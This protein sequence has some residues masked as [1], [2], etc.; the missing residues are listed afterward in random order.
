MQCA[1]LTI[2][3]RMKHTY[4]ASGSFGDCLTGSNSD[5]FLLVLLNSYFPLITL[6]RSPV[7][8][9]CSCVGMRLSAV[10]LRGKRIYRDKLE[11]LRKRVWDSH[12]SVLKVDKLRVPE[13]LLTDPNC[14]LQDAEDMFASTRYDDALAEEIEIGVPPEVALKLE[15]ARKQR[16]QPWSPTAF[17]PRY[18]PNSPSLI[19][20]NERRFSKGLDQASL[21]TNTLI[22]PGTPPCMTDL[23]TRV[24]R[25]ICSTSTDSPPSD[26]NW[27]SHLRNS[28]ERAILHAH[29]WH[30][31]ETKLPRRFRPELPIWKHKAEF[32]IHPQQATRF[33]FQN[34]FRILDQQTDSIASAIDAPLKMS[35]TE[36]PPW[37]LTRD[38]FLE[39]HYFWGN[40]ARR[41]AFAE[42]HDVVVSGRNP[43]PCFVPDS[44]GIRELCVSHSLPVR[45][46]GPM[47]PLVD[48]KAT[49]YYRDD[50]T[51]GWLRSDRPYP[52]PHLITINF[53]L[54]N[55]WSDF[56]EPEADP[57]RPEQRQAAALMH[58][59]ASTLAHARSL[60]IHSGVLPTP[61]CVQGVCSDGVYFDYVFFQLNTLE[62]PDPKTEAPHSSATATTTRNIAWIN[63]NLRLFD[64]Q[65]PKRS[66]LRNTKY[67]DLDMSVF[68]HLASAHLWGL[69]GNRL[70][71]HHSHSISDRSGLRAIS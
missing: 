1:L 9:V 68:C 65:V 57:V 44:E 60:G 4:S 49:T 32:G 54:P 61:I 25:T 22:L 59:F 34:L 8:L 24:E 53:S 14:P 20:T 69:V 58:C 27:V 10:L 43:L 41:I 15:A 39:T 67:C 56:L 36:L 16:M 11:Y 13:R 62:F 64:K 30:T 47:S 31:D 46:L 52:Y 28:V 38:R 17:D 35:S 5:A 26:A 42:H 71:S 66:M 55:V 21:L 37:W 19:F 51:D 40:P 48:L 6:F 50:S 18:H 3:N 45:T 70:A 33:L 29:V 12:G 63:G 2:P 23:L 7:V